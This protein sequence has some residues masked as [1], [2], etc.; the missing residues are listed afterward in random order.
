MQKHASSCCDIYT[1][2]LSTTLVLV[3]LKDLAQ[4]S[5]SLLQAAIYDDRFPALFD[6]EVYGNL[7]GM[8]ELNNLG[9]GACT[10]HTACAF[11]HGLHLCF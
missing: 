6:L 1:A 3:D 9:T 11:K 8:F 7:I 5:L 2:R 4:E 10:F